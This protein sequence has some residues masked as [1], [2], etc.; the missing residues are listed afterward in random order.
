MLLKPAQGLDVALSSLAGGAGFD[1]LRIQGNDFFLSA[2]GFEGGLIDLCGSDLRLSA[3][4]L[5]PNIGVVELDQQ[6]PPFDT[7]ALFDEQALDR[8]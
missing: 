1:E 3:G 4:S 8:G 5:R 2:S 7:I 6:L